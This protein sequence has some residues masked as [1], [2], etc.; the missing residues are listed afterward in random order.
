M[1]TPCHLS[2][3]PNPQGRPVLL[4]PKTGC[5]NLTLLVDD[6]TAHCEVHNRCYCTDTHFLINII[7]LS[8]QPVHPSA[9]DNGL[10]DGRAC[11]PVQI[12]HFDP[13]S[14]PLRM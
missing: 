10:D 14:R 2:R 11:G 1:D 13:F 9:V 7:P 12:P 3:R 4:L 8:C 5:E 6:N